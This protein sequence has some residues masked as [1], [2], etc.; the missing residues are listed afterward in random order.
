[1]HHGEAKY[2][3]IINGRTSHQGIGI[4]IVITKIETIKI[5]TEIGILE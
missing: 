5:S 4:N 1:M 2:R 3:P